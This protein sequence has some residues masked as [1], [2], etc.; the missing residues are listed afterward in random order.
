[1]G[2][3][4]LSESDLIL[5]LNKQESVLKILLDLSQLQ[6]AENDSLGLDNIM[7]KKDKCISELKKIDLILEKWYLENVRPLNKIEQNL[8]KNIH[9]LLEKI[10]I[11][12]GD[13]EKVLGQEKNAVSLQISQISNQ[14]QYRKNTTVKRIKIKNMKT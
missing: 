9:N 14:M 8:E 11:S 4:K 2:N 7:N 5:I 13:F 3:K 12:E 10:I 6:L 1:M